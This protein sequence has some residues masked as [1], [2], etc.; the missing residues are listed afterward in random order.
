[1]TEVHPSLIV[2]DVGVENVD[3]IA[4]C[5][6]LR[7]NPGTAKVPIALLQNGEADGLAG[8]EAGADECVVKPFEPELFFDR[9]ISLLPGARIRAS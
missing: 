9:L 1:M 5:R 8:F 3:G 2:V 6:A 7:Q 4:A